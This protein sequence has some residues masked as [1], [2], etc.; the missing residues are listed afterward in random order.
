MGANVNFKPMNDFFNKHKGDKNNM[1]T[2]EEQ[3][4]MQAIQNI[5]RKLPE[6]TLRDLFAMCFV[7]SG[8]FSSRGSGSY[9]DDDYGKWAYKYADVMLEARKQ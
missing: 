5:N 9:I 4:T 1:T 6:V 2:V 3:R 7:I 8:K